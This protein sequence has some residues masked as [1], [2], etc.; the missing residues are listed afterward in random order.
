M[1]VYKCKCCNEPCILVVKED[2]TMPCKCPYGYGI[3]DT[4]EWKEV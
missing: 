1:K 2:G 3:Y 4:S